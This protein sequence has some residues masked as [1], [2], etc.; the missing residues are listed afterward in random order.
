MQHNPMVSIPVAVWVHIGF[1]FPRDRRSL[2][3]IVPNVLLSVLQ[4]SYFLFSPGDLA[5]ITLNTFQ[6]ILNMSYSYFNLLRQSLL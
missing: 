2:L 5:P 4:L 1:L 6:A 3:T